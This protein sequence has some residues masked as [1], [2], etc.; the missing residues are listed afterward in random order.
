MSA[1]AKRRIHEEAPTLRLEVS[2]D[3]VEENWLMLAFLNRSVSPLPFS[4]LSTVGCRLSTSLHDSNFE[5][6]S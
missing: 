1:G 4:L 5:S 2:H 6:S 3:L